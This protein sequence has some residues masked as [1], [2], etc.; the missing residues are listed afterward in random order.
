MPPKAKGL[1]LIGIR[2][3]PDTWR[4]LQLYAAATDRRGLQEVLRPV[5]EAHAEQYAKLPEVQAMT[6]AAQQLREREGKESK[7]SRS[8]KLRRLERTARPK[9]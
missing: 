6:A 9:D 7:A 3:S 4:T 1:R 5:I 2:V 8:G